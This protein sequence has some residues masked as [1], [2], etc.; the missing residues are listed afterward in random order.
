MEEH[1]Y[2]LPSCVPGKNFSY[3]D[4]EPIEAVFEITANKLNF[5]KTNEANEGNNKIFTFIEH[6]LLYLLLYF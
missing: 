1:R 3:S 5:E 6:Y 2:S 4:H